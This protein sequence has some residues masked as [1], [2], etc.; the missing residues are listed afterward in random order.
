MALAGCVSQS[1]K[2]EMKDL[3]IIEKIPK[4]LHNI[5]ASF[6]RASHYPTGQ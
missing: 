6:Y 4:L 2:V 5:G 3:E 1:F